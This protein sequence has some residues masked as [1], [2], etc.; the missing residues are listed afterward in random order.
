MK[1][2]AIQLFLFFVT[3]VSLRAFVAFFLILHSS[4]FIYSVRN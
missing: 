4:F 2:E 1:N 3:F